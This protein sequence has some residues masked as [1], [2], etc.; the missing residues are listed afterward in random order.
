VLVTH[1]GEHDDGERQRNGAAPPPAHT[2]PLP[3]GRLKSKQ[4]E[5]EAWLLAAWQGRLQS[6]QHD[7][8]FGNAA[9]DLQLDIVRAARFSSRRVRSAPLCASST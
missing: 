9:D 4:H 6:I 1:P 5:I 3:S 8:R 7:H 2:R